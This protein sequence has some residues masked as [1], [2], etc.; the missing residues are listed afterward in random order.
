MDGQ[1]LLNRRKLDRIRF[2]YGSYM[3]TCFFPS[4]QQLALKTVKPASDW[5]FLTPWVRFGS[6]AQNT[7]MELY[8]LLTATHYRSALQSIL[9][10]NNIFEMTAPD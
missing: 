1:W 8:N 5:M 6:I 10:V 7:G 4:R 2:V 3:I 9:H